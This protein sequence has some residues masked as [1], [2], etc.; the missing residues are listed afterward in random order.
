MKKFLTYADHDSAL[1]RCITFWILYIDG[2]ILFFVSMIIISNASKFQISFLEYVASRF[3]IV[4]LAIITGILLGYFIGKTKHVYHSF[5]QSKYNERVVYIHKLKTERNN[6]LKDFD[7]EFER[8]KKIFSW[9]VNNKKLEFTPYEYFSMV[10]NNF[11][12]CDENVY[13]ESDLLKSQK[14]FDDACHSADLS[15]FNND[16]LKI[17]GKLFSDLESQWREVY[18]RKVDRE[19]KILDNLRDRLKE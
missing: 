9:G 1:F 14:I 18:Q 17:L 15:D 7:Q 2:I 3:N 19:Q 16:S 6:N 5:L 8:I 4:I 12:A 11:T 10:W 13:S